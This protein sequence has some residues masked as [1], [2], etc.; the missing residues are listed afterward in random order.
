MQSMEN[1]RAK[2]EPDLGYYFHPNDDAD[3]PGHPR[4]D[5]ILR[6]TPTERHFDPVRASFVVASTSGGTDKLVVHHPWGLGQRYR[7]CAGRI[8]LMD[9]RGKP[10]EAF[11]LGGDL[12]IEC[13][14]RRTVCMLRSP[15]PIFH[16]Y[17]ALDM[18]VCF[19]SEMEILLAQ[20]KAHWNPAHPH[21]FEEHL[22]R[23]EPLQLY[24]CL[25]QCMDDKGDDLH[26]GS[27]T[28]DFDMRHFVADEMARLKAQ[29]NWPQVICSP[30]Q[31]FSDGL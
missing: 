13:D 21:A 20:Q 7:V 1:L 6:A 14:Q 29:G 3:H 30:E 28:L 23:V 11:S 2:Q 25:L 31:L 22:A 5:V 18:P 15:A 19:V 4:L 17:S 10:V 27:G 26:S 12:Q 8:N 9:R 16:L 24:A